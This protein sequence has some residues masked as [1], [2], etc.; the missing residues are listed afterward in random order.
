MCQDSQ[1]LTS[2]SCRATGRGWAG[3][4]TVGC[5]KWL[6]ESSLLWSDCSSQKDCGSGLVI[7]L[8]QFMQHLS[9][10]LA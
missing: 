4:S 2:G 10:L 1:E 8:S 6:S 7:L 3:K 9:D 5:L